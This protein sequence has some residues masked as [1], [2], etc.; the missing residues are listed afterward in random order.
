MDRH[1][2]IYCRN[3]FQDF[4]DPRV[5]ERY[6]PRK[7]K[8][9]EPYHAMPMGKELEEHEKLCMECRFR[10]LEIS[11]P[12]CVICQNNHLE[13]I[14]FNGANYVYNCIACGETLYARRDILWEEDKK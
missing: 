12:R 2:P 11:E 6:A 13:F 1:I 4:C 3:L 14:K 5:R 10:E 8:L 9:G 7:T